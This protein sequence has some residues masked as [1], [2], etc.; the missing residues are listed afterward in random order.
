M[1]AA[2]LKQLLAR[3]RVVSSKLERAA[4]LC[5]EW[6]SNEPSPATFVLRGLFHDLIRRGWDDPQGV[7]AAQYKPFNDLVMPRLRA[8]V[9]LLAG[10]P[11]ADPAAE[12]ENLV[13]AY[14]DSL[15]AT[16]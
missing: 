13:V 5:D 15:N 2:K 9:D 12:L 1:S 16:P 11:S 8:L 3:G 14:R 6:Y 4:E 10:T 7:P